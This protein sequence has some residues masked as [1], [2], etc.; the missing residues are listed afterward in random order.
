MKNTEIKLLHS[1]DQRRIFKMLSWHLGSNL[2]CRSVQNAVLDFLNESYRFAKKQVSHSDGLEVIHN[3]STLQHRKSVAF[4][5][6]KVF[7]NNI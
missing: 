3:F 5:I 6:S 1:V 2:R 7:F 4:R